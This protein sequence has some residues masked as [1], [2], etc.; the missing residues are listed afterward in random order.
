MFHSQK[1]KEKQILTEE[2]QKKIEDKLDKIKAIQT[3]ILKMKND[4]ESDIKNLDILLK[5]GI[6]MPDFS[7]MWSYRKEL[8]SWHKSQISQ[9]DFFKFLQK[10]LENISGI[11]LR[12]PKSY[13]LWHH[14]YKIYK[15]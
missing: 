8:I 4:K 9:E 12:N 13:V 1:K 6:L 15:I 2:E 14:R 5:A 7:T 11:M 10:E 3:R